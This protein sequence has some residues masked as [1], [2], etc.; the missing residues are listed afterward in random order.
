MNTIFL[1]TVGLVALWDR[2]DQ[3]HLAG[4]ACLAT[5]DPLATRLVSTSLVMLECANHAA[6]RPYRLEVVRMRDDLGMAGDLYEP[7][8]DE[9]HQ[10]WDDYARGIVGSASVVDLISFAVM[11]RLGIIEAFT[12]DKHFTAAGFKVLF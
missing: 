5:L 12:N 6:R 4:K 11:R 8:T 3:W 7:S 10:A 1:D 9:I 2:R